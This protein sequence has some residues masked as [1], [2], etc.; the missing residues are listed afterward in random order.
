MPGLTFDVTL[1]SL[2]YGQIG[3]SET[4]ASGRGTRDSLT[5][6]ARSRFGD[7]GAFA[8]GGRMARRS[9]GGGRPPGVTVGVDSISLQLPGGT[10]RLQQPTE[11]VMNDSVVA[12]GATT[13]RSESDSGRIVLD[14]HLPARGPLVAHMQLD[15]FPVAGIYTLF[16]HDTAGV[17]GTI[18]ATLGLAGTRTDPCTSARSR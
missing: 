2:R 14:G 13:L 8:T 4:F 1:D 15:A 10:W 11:I 17:G 6:F 7:V 16:E 3:F 18:N 12:I 5:W 9:P